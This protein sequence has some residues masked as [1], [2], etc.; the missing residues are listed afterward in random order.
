M[1][2][3]INRILDYVH[4]ENFDLADETYSETKDNFIFD[5]KTLHPLKYCL[6][7]ER[8]K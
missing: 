7:K 2:L 3:P 6:E 4:P 8:V 5:Y 1:L